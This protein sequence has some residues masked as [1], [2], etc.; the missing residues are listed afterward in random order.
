MERHPRFDGTVQRAKRV[1]LGLAYRLLLFIAKVISR[2]EALVR[3][4]Q[5]DIVEWVISGVPSTIA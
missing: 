1:I 2:V 4:L 5:A 3:V